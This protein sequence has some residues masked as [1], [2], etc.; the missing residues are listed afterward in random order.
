MTT[1]VGF[2][3][4]RHP[5]PGHCFRRSCVREPSHPEDASA[6]PTMAAFDLPKTPGGTNWGTIDRFKTPKARSPGPLAY[7]NDGNLNFT[8]STLSVSSSQ[9]SFTFSERFAVPGS[10][11]RRRAAEAGDSPLH[12]PPALGAQP[13]SRLPSRPA[14]TI[15]PKVKTYKTPTRAHT[16]APGQY[17]LP[18]PRVYEDRREQSFGTDDRFGSSGPRSAAKLPGAGD[19]DASDSV[20]RTDT[21]TSVS[22]P[23]TGRKFTRTAERSPGPCVA[24]EGAL[25]KNRV[26]KQEPIWSAGLK[27]RP[28]R[29]P[30]E[31]SPSTYDAR[32]L[33]WSNKKPLGRSATASGMSHSS[34][35]LNLHK[36]VQASQ[37]VAS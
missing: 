37:P 20:T 1:T 6:V 28:A 15:G 9:P 16:P 32:S 24:G 11:A 33:Y 21:Y 7:E 34:T 4:N 36:P 22:L 14:Y 23:F 17:T 35:G 31:P 25:A 19:Y 18:Q 13:N 26:L 29:L 30:L 10:E 8:R 5:W 2:V 3:T 27:Q 12:I